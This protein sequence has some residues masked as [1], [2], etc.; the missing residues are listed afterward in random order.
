MPELKE[1]LLA[2]VAALEAAWTKA[3]QECPGVIVERH[4]E[5]AITAVAAAIANLP[6][7]YA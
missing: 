4:L 3:V 5:R 6:D 2:I 1:D 7:E